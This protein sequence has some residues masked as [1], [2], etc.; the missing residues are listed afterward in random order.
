M[1]LDLDHMDDGGMYVWA[2]II[3]V[4]AAAGGYAVTLAWQRWKDS[5]K[6]RSGD[7]PSPP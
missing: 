7:E 3:A 6:A 4:L 5:R 2:G 1:N